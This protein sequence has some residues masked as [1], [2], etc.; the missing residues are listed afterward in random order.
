MAYDLAASSFRDAP[1]GAGPESFR[2]EKPLIRRPSAAT[3]SHKGRRKPSSVLI[4]APSPLVGEGS[5]DAG[6][7]LIQVRG[8]LRR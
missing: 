8:R 6:H 5:S 4:A 3:F 2:G 7:E 1:I